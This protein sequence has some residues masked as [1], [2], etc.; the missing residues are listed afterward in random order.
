MRKRA[1]KTSW[2]LLLVGASL[3]EW[4]IAQTDLKRHL[5]GACAGWH[6]SAA[7]RDWMEGES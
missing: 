7:V 5:A 3:I 4:K 2:H 6:L 1:I